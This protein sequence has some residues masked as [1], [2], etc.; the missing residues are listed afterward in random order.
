MHYACCYISMSCKSCYWQ[1]STAACSLVSESQFEALLSNASSVKLL[2]VLIWA[3]AEFAIF[4]L[5]SFRLCLSSWL[6]NCASTCAEKCVLNGI[7]M[8]TCMPCIC[9]CF[10]S[11]IYIKH[12]VSAITNT[13]APQ[14]KTAAVLLLLLAAA[15]SSEG[16][17]EMETSGASTVIWYEMLTVCSSWKLGW[18]QEQ[19]PSGDIVFPFDSTGVTDPTKSPAW[20]QEMAAA[21]PFMTAGHAL[22]QS[23]LDQASITVKAQLLFKHAYL[24]MATAISTS[25]WKPAALEP[26]KAPSN[27]VSQAARWLHRTAANTVEEWA[28]YSFLWQSAYRGTTLRQQ[29]VNVDSLL[30]MVQEQ[31]ELQQTAESLLHST[32]GRCPEQLLQ[33]L[34]RQILSFGVNSGLG[35]QQQVEKDTL[36][37]FDACPSNVP[38]IFSILRTHAQVHLILQASSSHQHHQASCER[39]TLICASC[40]PHDVML[41]TG[42]GTAVSGMHAF[43]CLQ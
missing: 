42:A 21:L 17:R 20:A 5:Q 4:S 40:K 34:Y 11:L 23:I 16:M 22:I 27:P 15:G 26:G 7:S 19:L 1:Q 29:I 12:R 41:T 8:S 10:A 30:K 13:H 38:S 9:V 36:V 14:V 32:Q 3:M 35:V 6:T 2:L 31:K 28:F 43:H 33:L 18:E 24:T 39:C 25:Q 37:R